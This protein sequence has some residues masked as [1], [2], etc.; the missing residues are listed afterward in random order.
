MSG[1]NNFAIRHATKYETTYSNIFRTHYPQ[2]QK[3]AD[4]FE[5]L[6]GEI[7]EELV[8]EPHVHNATQMAWPRGA[9]KAGCDLYKLRFVMPGLKGASR[10]GRLLYLV[11][12]TNR[13][14]HFLWI[15]THQEYKR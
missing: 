7:E 2:D 13:E 4:D 5:R 6:L 1:A 12:R 9:S 8:E 3:D 10:L 11:D 14:I 15:Y